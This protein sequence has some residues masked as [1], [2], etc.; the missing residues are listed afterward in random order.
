MIG[1]LIGGGLGLASSLFGG[2]K[3]AKAAKKQQKIIDNA[4]ARNEAWFNKEYY[5][6][7][8]DRSDAQAAMG[9]VRDY[10]KRAN[11]RTD[12]MAAVTGATPEA[13]A[14]QKEATANA[15]GNTASAIQ[16]NADAYKQNAL[17]RYQAQEAALDNAAIGQ[18][19]MTEAGTANLADMGLQTAGVIANAA[20]SSAK[21]KLTKQEIADFGQKEAQKAIEKLNT[22][23]NNSSVWYRK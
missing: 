10:M 23:Y 8:M 16:A 11:E 20:I 7:Y 12:N 17:N 6:D 9:R 4:R 18:Q 14:A 22:N 5:Q 2:I 3:A 21:P 15:I 1:A 13:V 19:Q